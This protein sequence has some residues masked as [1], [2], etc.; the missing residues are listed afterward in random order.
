ML[1]GFSLNN[2]G[3]TSLEKIK[4][5]EKISCINKLKIKRAVT[6]KT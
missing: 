5:A 1:D 3:I 6:L 2:G 4:E